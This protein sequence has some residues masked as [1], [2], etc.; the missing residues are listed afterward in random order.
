MCMS[1]IQ[2]GSEAQVK[3]S[4]GVRSAG[5][6]EHHTGYETDVKEII[7]WSADTKS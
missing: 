6:M 1:K 7:N 5:P 3:D 4:V 2:L